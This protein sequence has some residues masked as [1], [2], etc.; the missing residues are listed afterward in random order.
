[1]AAAVLATVTI[2]IT[3]TN[4]VPVIAG[5]VERVRCKRMWAST[6][7]SLATAVHADQPTWIGAVA[8]RRANTAPPAATA[9]AAFTV[10]ADGTWTYT[11][12][13]ARPRSSSSAAGQTIT[14]SFTVGRPATAPPARSSR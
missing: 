10:A 8:P 2:T 6:A 9:T 14:D 12:D 1:M 3:G 11:A 7:G 4:D 13:N 5:V